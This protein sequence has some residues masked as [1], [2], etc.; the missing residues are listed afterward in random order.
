MR[1]RAVTATILSVLILAVALPAAAGGAVTMDPVKI[2]SKTEFHPAA[3]DGG[4]NAYFAWSQIVR[5][6]SHVFLETN[7]GAKDQIDAGEYGYTGGFAPGDDRLIYQQVDLNARHYDSNV[8]FYDATTDSTSGL[9]SPI[10]NDHWQWYPTFDMDGSDTLWVLYG[11][12]RFKRPTSPWR[13]F[14]WDEAS[15]T[16][17]VL[18]ETTN[19]CG[20]ISPGTIAYPFV[21]WSK[22]AEGNV[23]RMNL[24]T[25]TTEKLTLPGDRDEH[26][27]ALTADGT[28]YVTQ[29]G[30]ACGT[31][32]KIFRIDPDGTATLIASMPPG[33]EAN[34]LAP[35]DTGTGIDVYI[36]RYTCSTKR[37]DIYVI[38]DADT[39]AGTAAM[40]VDSGSAGRVGG[41]RFPVGS[42]PPSP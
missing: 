17:R 40:P 3:G 38:R 27:I 42:V 18:A 31:N 30:A 7:G 6:H 34:T 37:Y 25:D 11:E 35:F 39:V 29:D 2:T 13:V 12:N 1:N 16:R 10:N 28:A 26:A 36:D 9:G 8:K 21:G 22:G 24:D 14:V 32:G 5:R 20:C 19:R 41:G 15:G 4:T 33:T 23:W